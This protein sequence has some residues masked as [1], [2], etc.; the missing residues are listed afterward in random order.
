MVTT[1]PPGDPFPRAIALPELLVDSDQDAVL[2]VAG[3]SKRFG[4]LAALTDYELKLRR[5]EVLGLIGP[6]GAG[7][8]TAFNLLTGVV[9]PSGGRIVLGGTDLTGASSEVFARA[10]IARTFQNV[11]LFRDLSVWENVAVGFHMRDGAGWLATILGLPG[12]RASEHR[13]RERSVGLLDVVGLAAVAGQRAGD[14]PYG[15]QRKVEIARALATGPS[16][17]L[18]DEPAAG[19]NTSETAALTDTLRDLAATV[20]AADGQRLAVIVVEHD[21]RLVMALCTRIQVLNRGLLLAEGTPAEIQRHEAVI[22][23]YLGSGR[24]TGRRHA[25]A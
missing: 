13:I 6:N 19:M 5:G 7:K 11:R 21:M 20:R 16:L 12:A 24:R 25:H 15:L 17:L 1:G 14:L 3:L 9:K 4:G 10:G 8:T 22:E 18:L 2:D 23:A